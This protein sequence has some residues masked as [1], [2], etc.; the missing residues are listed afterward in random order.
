M[1]WMK[2]GADW[3][4]SIRDGQLSS[5]IT[6]ER[7]GGWSLP[8]NGTYAEQVITYASEAGSN[9]R[10]ETGA[11]QIK[12]QA[13]Y[14]GTIRRVPLSGDRITAESYGWRRVY[15]VVPINKTTWKPHDRFGDTIVVYVQLLDEV[16][17]G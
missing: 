9:I 5:L 13:I 14:N 11:F 17:F 12:K 10:V 15:Q 3:L 16:Y 7:P 2:W 8:I 4:E 6:Y 1:N